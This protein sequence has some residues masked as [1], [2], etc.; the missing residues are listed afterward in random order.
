MPSVTD[1]Q[2]QITYRLLP[3]QRWPALHISSCRWCCTQAELQTTP[4]TCC[5]YQATALRSHHVPHFCRLCVARETDPSR[6]HAHPE[7]Q[8]LSTQSPMG[9]D[10]TLA[11]QKHTCSIDQCQ[12]PLVQSRPLIKLTQ[13]GARAIIFDYTILQQERP[14]FTQ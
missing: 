6:L 11:T 8:A 14:P 13:F 7:K 5:H 10:F 9:Q 1:R 2:A 3:F 12:A 4:Q